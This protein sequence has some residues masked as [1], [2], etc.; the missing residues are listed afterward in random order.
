[1]LTFLTFLVCRSHSYTN[2]IHSVNNNHT[3][4]IAIATVQCFVKDIWFNMAPKFNGN[5]AGNSVKPREVLCVLM[6][7]LS[8]CIIVELYVKKT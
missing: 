3:Y 8:N 4:G 1:M 6:R 2:G 5:Y 7:I